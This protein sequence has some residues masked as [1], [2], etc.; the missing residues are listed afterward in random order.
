MS[1]TLP[2]AEVVGKA[3]S[4]LKI[5]YGASQLH[6][7]LCG[8]LCAGSLLD[9][10]TFFKTLL[11]HAT[12]AD[13]ES[14]ETLASLYRTTKSELQSMTFEFHLLVSDDWELEKRAR[15]LGE[16]C[17]GFSEG[18]SD[19]GIQ[20]DSLSQSEAKDALLHIHEIAEID[21]ENTS[22]SEAD[23]KAFFEIFEYVRM[24]ALMIYSEINQAEGQGVK[25]NSTLH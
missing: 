20:F 1:E 5:G 9:E 24:A 18:L 25:G 7:L 13:T 23:E 11:Q 4:S 21:Y 22:V 15:A 10:K 3:I 16:W 14:I 19:G 12:N 17:E 6:G 2:S 8:F